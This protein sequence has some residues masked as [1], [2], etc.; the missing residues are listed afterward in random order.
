MVRV[1][2]PVRSTKTVKIIGKE[3]LNT[4]SSKLEGE[5]KEN[6]IEIKKKQKKIKEDRKEKRNKK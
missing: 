5:V 2:R 4:P 1:V 3:T 6:I